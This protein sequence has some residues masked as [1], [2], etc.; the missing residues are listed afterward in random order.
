MQTARVSRQELPEDFGLP[1]EVLV[2]RLSRRA[3]RLQEVQPSM[4]VIDL[5]RL[6]VAALRGERVR[7][8]PLSRPPR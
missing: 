6:V 7:T 1:T 2:E 5:L 8:F 4:S 3:R